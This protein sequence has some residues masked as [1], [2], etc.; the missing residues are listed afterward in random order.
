MTTTRPT[1]DVSALLPW[2]PPKEVQTAHGPLLLRKAA[3]TDAFWRVW[4]A[5]KAGIKA[6]GMSV[7]RD[8]RTGNYEVCWWAELDTGRQAQIAADIDASSATTADIDV[9][10][11]AGLAY[12]PYQLAG[13]KWAAEHDNCL[14]GDEAGLGKS[15][16]TVGLLNYYPSIR[17]VL[18]VCPATL[19][20]NWSRELEKWLVRPAAV[21]VVRSG[22]QPWPNASI[23]VVN[24]DL[25]RKF[26]GAIRR[27]TWDLLVV[28]ESQ[29][30]RNHTSHRCKEVWGQRRG[31][32]EWTVTP[33]P[34]KRKLCLSG[35]PLVN[36]PIELWTTLHGL[37]PDLYPNRF[38][39]ANR[40]CE[41][42]RTFYGWDFTGAANL[43]ELQAKMRRHLMIRRRKE[44]VLADLP[45]V[46]KQVIE[47]PANGAAGLIKDEL[48]TWERLQARK[49]ELE[50]AVAAAKTSDDPQVYRDAVDALKDHNTTTFTEM[51]KRRHATGIAKLP[52]IID[53]LHGLLDDDMAAKFILF[54][55]HHDVISSIAAEFP[56][57]SVTL[58]G[59]TALTARQAAVD[60]F[61]TDPACRLFV[62]NM[63]AAG[64]GITLTA[65][66]HVIIA[67]SD[68]VPAT[69]EQ[70]IARAARIGQRDSVLAQFLV[71]EGSL[72]ARMAKTVV[73]KQEVIDQTLDKQP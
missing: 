42:K 62:G 46:R 1:I 29:F 66:S 71:F 53:H 7:T 61:Q 14:I 52:A 33:I 69:I 67:E 51:A 35:T 60:R 20:I 16:E 18:I 19:R 24:Y 30:L 48:S 22:T 40:H 3:P 38:A 70:A 10:C 37:R 11:P 39:F 15:I 58:T 9:P 55:W 45:A 49:A 27:Q 21:E 65:S 73:A 64:V 26:H 44:D 13:I 12:L 8:N 41:P 54:G 68:W 63:Q 32:N 23:I 36:R 50:T 59:Q 28:D 6:E 34:A 31:K 47:L 43:D 4:R 5:D 17:R 56:A 72:D 57:L 25:L 2:G